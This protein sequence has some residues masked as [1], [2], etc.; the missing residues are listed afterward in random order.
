MKGSTE[1]KLIL[2]HIFDTGIGFDAFQIGSIDFPSLKIKN[3][4]LLDKYFNK[5][6]MENPYKSPRVL[7]LKN[8]PDKSLLLDEPEDIVTVSK[9]DICLLPPLLKKA[10]VSMG[11]WGVYRLNQKVYFLYDA[12][13]L[14]GAV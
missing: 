8:F 10:T 12:D 4:I 2:F 9:A 14:A 11:L 1:I 3:A 5:T 6:G 13:I 7:F